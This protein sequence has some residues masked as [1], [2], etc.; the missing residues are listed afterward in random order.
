MFLVS[1]LLRLFRNCDD[2][3]DVPDALQLLVHLAAAHGHR[4][5]ILTSLFLDLKDQFLILIF[6]I[7]ITYICEVLRVFLRLVNLSAFDFWSWHLKTLPLAHLWCFG[8]FG[9]NWLY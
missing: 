2:R 8:F 5:A 3:P 7:C 9:T 6:F 1:D 4:L